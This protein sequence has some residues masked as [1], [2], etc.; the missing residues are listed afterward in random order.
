LIERPVGL[1]DVTVTVT[2]ARDHGFLL[3]SDHENSPG[4]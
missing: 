1:T 2:G 3:T 4:R